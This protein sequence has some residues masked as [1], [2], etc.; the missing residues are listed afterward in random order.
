MEAAIGHQVCSVIDKLF[1]CLDK[2]AAP[3]QAREFPAHYHIINF[4]N[5]NGEVAYLI[6]DFDKKS[7]YYVYPK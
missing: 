3:K 1:D 4:T 2:L 7:K 5:N 6:Y